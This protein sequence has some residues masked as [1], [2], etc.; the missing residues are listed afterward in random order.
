MMKVLWI[1]NILFPEAEIILKGKGELRSTGG[2]LL[3]SA[4]ELALDN[5]VKLYVATVSN[6]VSELTTL[7]GEKITY[8]II[9]Y[10]QGILKQNFEYCCYWT[11]IYNQICPDVVHIHGTEFSHGNAYLYSVKSDNVV[12]SIQGMTSAYYPYFTC[13]LNV[14]D[15]LRHYTL[16]D[17]I[18]GSIYKQK[19]DFKKRGKYEIDTISKVSHVIGRTSWDKARVWAINP[20]CTYHF[21]NESLREEFYS[22]ESW[23]YSKCKK[24][25]IFLSQGSHPIKGLH[26]LLKA[27]P[28]ILRH[29]QDATVR[30]SGNNILGVPSIKLSGYARY[31]KRLIK[32]YK[33]ENKVTFIG[34]L[35]ACEIKKEL[36]SSNL[37]LCPSSIENSPNSLGEAQILGVPSISSYVGGTMDM[38]RGNEDFLYRFEE[39]EMLAYKI[40]NVFANADNQIDMRNTALGRHNRVVNK[41]TL[42]SIYKKIVESKVTK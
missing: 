26:Q 18:R 21:C 20:N 6:L 1:V 38:M 2:W 31:I 27:M 41:D 8:Y 23:E 3:S 19:K 4:N 42:L 35:N 22:D 9:P 12:V 14:R 39:V 11:A 16:K 37:F 33:L 34:E 36:L 5:N 29:Y 13:G 24:H 15:V 32:E 10:G 30:I 40:C 17:F 7:E 28:L 25:S